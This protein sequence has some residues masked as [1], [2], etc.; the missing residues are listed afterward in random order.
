[1]LVI[2]ILGFF[3]HLNFYSKS[4]PEETSYKSQVVV[5]LIFPLPML[6]QFLAPILKYVGVYLELTMAIF[7]GGLNEED[8][9]TDDNEE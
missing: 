9:V 2:Y 3:Y 8:S 1:M 4:M 6:C 5:A 7:S